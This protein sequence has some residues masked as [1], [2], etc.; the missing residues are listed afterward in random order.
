MTYARRI[1]AATLLALSLGGLAGSP[2]PAEAQ[3]I[4]FKCVRQFVIICVGCLPTS[5]PGRRTCI[6]PPTAACCF[7]S[8]GCNTLI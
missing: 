6:E 4:C 8:G 7:T 2:P 5:G 3:G 1:T